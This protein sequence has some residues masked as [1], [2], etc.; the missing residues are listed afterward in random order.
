MLFLHP[1][2][3]QNPCFTILDG[4]LHAVIEQDPSESVRKFIKYDSP[5]LLEQIIRE[6]QTRRRLEN[7]SK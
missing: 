3:E 4:L 6:G 1:L 2:T 7:S 5:K